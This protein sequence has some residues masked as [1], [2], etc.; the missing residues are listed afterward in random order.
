MFVRTRSRSRRALV[1]A[2]SVPNMSDAA[3]TTRAATRRWTSAS[4]ILRL[5]QAG[6]HNTACHVALN[7]RCASAP[8]VADGGGTHG[9]D[10]HSLARPTA[11]T[12]TRSP[13]WSFIGCHSHRVGLHAEPTG[14]WCWARQKAQG[15]SRLDTDAPWV[16]GR[17]VLPMTWICWAR[18][19]LFSLSDHDTPRGAVAGAHTAARR[20]TA[21]CVSRPAV[22]KPAEPI[23]GL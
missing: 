5:N 14:V 1:D 9:V 21:D 22:R 18:L 19:R 11:A 2:W 20:S 13:R 4:A 8:M 15:R 23:G 7:R 17:C 3:S 16:T 12:R 10:E 6:V